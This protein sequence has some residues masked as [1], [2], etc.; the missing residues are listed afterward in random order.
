MTKMIV[1]FSLSPGK[2]IILSIND[3]NFT[4]QTPITITAGYTLD[5]FLQFSQD[6]DRGLNGQVQ[7]G[8]AVRTRLVFFSRLILLLVTM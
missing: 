1:E 3:Y 4:R 6:N 5:I 2:Y 7:I 8:L